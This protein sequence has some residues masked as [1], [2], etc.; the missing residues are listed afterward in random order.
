VRYTECGQKNRDGRRF[1]AACGAQLEA[2]A[3]LAQLSGEAAAR[4]REVR[5]AHRLFSAMGATGHAE[6]ISRQLSGF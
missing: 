5:G 6:R 2:R 1:C 3:E 4:Q